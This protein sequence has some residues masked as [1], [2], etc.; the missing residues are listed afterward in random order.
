V[1]VG[2]VRSQVAV[3][4]GGGSTYEALVADWTFHSFDY[5]HRSNSFSSYLKKLAHERAK[6][7]VKN[8]EYLIN[9]IH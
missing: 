6:E 3:K 5:D 4:L 8:I 7:D 9:Y 1:L 2:H